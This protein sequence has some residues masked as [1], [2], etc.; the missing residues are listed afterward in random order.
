MI[1]DTMTSRSERKQSAAQPVYDQLKT[2]ILERKLVPGERLLERDLAERFKVSR[3]PVRDALKM[4]ETD[5]LIQRSHYQG[6]IVAVMSA[7]EVLDTLDAREVVEGLIARKATERI[8]AKQIELLSE[9]CVRMQRCVAKNDG[10]GYLEQALV[11]RE[12][13]VEAAGSELLAGIAASLF[14]RLRI[15]STR[16]VFSPGRMKVALRDHRSVLEAIKR[17]DPA[18]AERHNRQ[19]I[20]GIRSEILAGLG[21]LNA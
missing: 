12:V 16:S 21:P 1:K 18:S 14:Q 15:A 13:L 19:R 5:N 9:C 3:T 8:S 2:M 7:E 4:L 6:T 10:G 11:F 20:R 17:R